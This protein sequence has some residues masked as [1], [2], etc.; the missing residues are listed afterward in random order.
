[1]DQPI[2]FIIKDQ[3]S[4][5]ELGLDTKI[6]QN[7]NGL[8]IF[9]MNSNHDIDTNSTLFNCLMDKVENNDFKTVCSAANRNDEGGPDIYGDDIIMY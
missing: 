3:L 8:R 4:I 7:G 9:V 1:M 2:K 5:S 6:L